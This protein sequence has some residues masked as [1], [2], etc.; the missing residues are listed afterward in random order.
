MAISIFGNLNANHGG[1]QARLA[2]ETLKIEK[3]F[4][5]EA[6]QP[7]D[8]GRHRSAQQGLEQQIVELQAQLKEEQAKASVEV[9]SL[10]SSLDHSEALIATQ[11]ELM[12]V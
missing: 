11:K 6:Q 4:A 10:R 1:L 3:Q 9:T 2:A 5:R 12:Q 7:A 8:R